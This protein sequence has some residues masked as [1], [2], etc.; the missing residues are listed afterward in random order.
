MT[1]PRR[2]H[3]GG[4]EEFAKLLPVFIYVFKHEV[5]RGRVFYSKNL[6]YAISR[7]FAAWTNYC[8]ELGSSQVL[9]VLQYST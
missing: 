8:A 9:V 6:P 7:I 5:L 3:V 2:R 1:V 4:V